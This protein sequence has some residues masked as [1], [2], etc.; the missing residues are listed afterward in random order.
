MELKDLKEG[1]EV[2]LVSGY[3]SDNATIKT[4]DRVTRTQIGIGRNRYDR[5]TGKCKGE[6]GW[7]R[8][9]LAVLTDKLRDKANREAYISD[10]RAAYWHK[11]T[12]EELAIAAELA[13]KS[14]LEEPA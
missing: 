12:T 10:C 3:S 2:A 4:I 7:H 6:T 9:R 11:L 14:R 1:D 13:R 5:A 8:S